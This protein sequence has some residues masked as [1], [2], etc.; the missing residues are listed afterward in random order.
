MK[1]FFILILII[2]SFFGCTKKQP[3]PEPVCK[4]VFKATGSAAS[5]IATV[6][7]CKNTGAI[8]ADISEPILQL[9]LCADTAAQSTLTDLICPQ[10]STILTS[11]VTGAIPASWQCS[12]AIVSDMI[13][14]Q[15]E[16]S[17]S[18]L[19]R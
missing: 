14:E 9:G 4:S 6:L 1:R 17:C 18:K 12:T 16:E 13:K 7:Q 8:A 15:L 19:V 2:S 10:I 3:L 5:L 11:L